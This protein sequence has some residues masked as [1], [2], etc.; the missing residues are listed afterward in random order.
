M[1]TK[2]ALVLMTA[3]A[4]ISDSLLHPFYPQYFAVVFGVRD[5]VSVGIYVASCSL[6]VLLA[7]PL[8]ARLARRVPVT[9]LL[10]A[11]QSAAALVAFACSVAESLPLFCAL[12][13]A[14]MALKASYLLIYPY[15]MSQEQPDQHLATIGLLAFVVYFGNVLA[16]LLSGAVLQLF[17]ARS[18]FLFMAAGDVLQTLTCVGLLLRARD[19][20]GQSRSGPAASRSAPTPVLRLG[21][22]MSVLY[23][24]AYLTEPFFSE[25]WHELAPGSS[26]LVTGAVF[27]VPGVAAL[28]ALY[29]NSHTSQSKRLRGAIVSAIAA[30]LAGLLLQVVHAPMAVLAGRCLYGWALFQAMV[31]LDLALFRNSTP[32]DYA[33]DFSRVNLFQGFGVML[34]SP[35]AGFLVASFGRTAPFV[36]ALFGFVIGAGLVLSLF[37]AELGEPPLSPSATS[38]RET[39]VATS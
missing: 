16:A 1:T 32:A 21:L 29:V 27:A 3:V 14:L 19:G 15:L 39:G 30:A 38:S 24:S 20:G 26:W 11:T 23:F 5:P 12:S 33:V 13:M 2:Q 25:Y 17:D 31:R 28:A 8:W 9:H 6:T 4:V 37:K 35:V 10:V 34:A 18:L 36:V 7:L 22:V